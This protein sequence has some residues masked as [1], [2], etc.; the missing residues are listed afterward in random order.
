MAYREIPSRI[1]DASVWAA[2]PTERG[3]LFQ[4]FERLLAVEDG[5][6]VDV[7]VAPE[8]RRFHKVFEAGGATY[9]RLEGTGLLQY[10]DRQLVRVAGGDRLAD[11]PV[12]GLLDLDGRPGGALL[13]VT[14]DELFRLDP[15][16]V[17][18]LVAVPTAATE[19]LRQTRAY[20]GCPVGPPDDPTLAVTTMGSGVLVVSPT[21][22]VIEHLNAEVGLTPDDL[23]LGCAT[24]VQ[25]GLWLAL[26]AGVV[27]VDAAA[28]L[29]TFDLR[30]GLDGAV[31]DAVRYEGSLYAATDR[32]VYR[33]RPSTDGAPARFEPVQLAGG[34]LGQAWSLLATDT[35]LL[36]AGTGGLFVVEGR[37][38]RAVLSESAF[39]VSSST[40]AG[41]AVVYAGLR[42]SLV[43]LKSVGGRWREV[44]RAQGIDG[45]VWSVFPVEGGAW[46]AEA[47]GRLLRI[48]ARGQVVHSYGEADGV[49]RGLASV[50]R[51]DES[52]AVLTADGPYRVTV[53]AD[54]VHFTPMHALRAVIEDVV[55]DLALGYG[56]WSDEAE[57]VWISGRERTQVMTRGERG[58]ADVTPVAFQRTAGVTG[59]LAESD[60]LWVPT[61]SGLLR[62]AGD[63]GGRYAAVVPAQVT[64]VEADTPVAIEDHHVS[65]PYGSPVRFRVAAA[66]FNG[67][68]LYRTQLVGHD[69]ASSAWSSETFR[70]YT[71][72]SPGDYAFRVEGLTAQG[73]ETRPATVAVHVPAPWYLT[74]WAAVL[75]ALLSGTVVAGVAYGASREQRRRADAER[76]RADEL[77]RLNAE[78]RRADEVKDSMLANTS[79]EL[80]TPL[81][82]ILGFAEVLSDHGDDEAREFAG[83]ILSGARR[84]LHTVNDLLDIARLRSGKVAL[85]PVATDAVAVAQRVAA[86]LMPLAVN[87]G[88]ALFVVPDGHAVPAVLDPEAFARIVTNLVSNAVKFSDAGAVTIHVDGRGTDVHL[89]VRDTGRGMEPRV[90]AP[91]LRHVR[92]GVHGVRPQRGGDGSGAGDHQS[93]RGP[94]GRTHRGR[95]HPRR[96]FYLPRD[97]PCRRQRRSRPG[98]FAPR[99]GRSGG[100][101][102]RGWG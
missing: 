66:A 35:G 56:V 92:A 99:I 94:D 32:G 10:R 46:V 98:C 4:T 84:L 68:T 51:L 93:S 71:N 34:D 55:G 81:T 16:A 52:L 60:V 76:A 22:E 9:V 13:V 70:D 30:L 25:G 53:E 28:P 15:A 88:L 82:A 27:R 50:Q 36:V 58:W 87:K 91:A 33:L 61:T 102:P 7:G 12:R 65:L 95:E 67:G 79:H 40:S 18:P 54:G 8:G 11:T 72:L 86:E 59:V 48:G 19:T 2:V 101:G 31:S 63:G 73:T 17:E 47:D 69:R 23:V 57:R 39:S 100:R 62:L 42:S 44:A 96:G 21:G 75:A 74:A 38:A 24:D 1:G 45:E 6:V 80:R 85:V 20:H 41:E 14:D 78:L 64:A 49:P 97:A 90:P 83:H 37:S 29:T 3:V 89:A 26:S 43:T 77:D 5:R